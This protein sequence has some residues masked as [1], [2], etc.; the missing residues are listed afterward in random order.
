[1]KY[2]GIYIHIPF[3]TEKCI[4]CDFYS[5]TKHENQID[6]FVERLCKEIRLKSSIID[7]KWKIDTIFIGG[8]TP[9][10][11]E[12][13]HIEK[14]IKNLDNTF[15]LNYLNEFT[16]EANPSEF[17]I[18]KMKTFNELGVNRVSFGFQSL[19]N[20]ILKFLTRWHTPEDCI[21]AY[22]NARTAGFENINIDMI[23]GIP[24]QSILQWEKDLNHIIDLNPEHISAYSL[25]VEKN[26][27]LHTYV[28]SNKII[29]PQEKIDI[30]M[31][32]HTMEAL[33]NGHYI[34]YEISNYSQKGKECKHNLHYWKRDPYL[35]FG[36]SAHGY[37]DNK[38][39]WN[40]RNLNQYIKKIDS[41]HLPIDDL[42]VLNEENIFNE[43]IINGLR[44]SE[45]I[46]MS[47]IKSKFSKQTYKSLTSKINDWSS[48]IEKSNGKIKLTKKGYFI[49]DE[50]TLDL[51]N[52]YIESY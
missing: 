32:S 10:L 19:N 18:K 2:G 14:I 3:C 12:P 49:A 31:Y 24:N 40:I 52:S 16:I 44:I 42:E 45:G 11:L 50:I 8:G 34:Q 29:M 25:T 4:Y 17:N 20:E 37:Y 26:T 21:R 30:D 1:M 5:L 46:N 43:M 48:H 22:K 41:N 51:M 38:R 47:K 15:N 27:P 35:A 36:P 9:S 7:L 13:F 6:T 23:Y 28:S 33:N 39:Y